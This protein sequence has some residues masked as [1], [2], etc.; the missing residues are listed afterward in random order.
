MSI[1]VTAVPR[2]CQVESFDSDGETLVYSAARDEAST[3]NRTATEIWS[4][5]DG[6]RSV[7]AIAGALADRYGV[8]A[9]ILLPDVA[10][11]CGVLAARGLVELDAGGRRVGTG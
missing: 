11:T 7:H 3:L 2:R 1:D 6:V 5:C 9:A 8:D 4:L 10:S